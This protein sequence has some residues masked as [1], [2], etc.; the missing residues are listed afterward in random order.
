METTITSNLKKP[1]FLP[2]K[3]DNLTLYII[4]LGYPNP[5]R[6]TNKIQLNSLKALK[7]YPNLNTVDRNV[8]FFNINVHEN[9]T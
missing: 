9:V 6:F 1:V 4:N 5:T 8:Y 7:N 3:E 2:V